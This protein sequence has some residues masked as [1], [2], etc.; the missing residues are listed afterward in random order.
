MG[1]AAIGMEMPRPPR[2]LRAG[3]PKA[4]ELLRIALLAGEREALT[5]ARRFC[6]RSG[7]LAL[8]ELVFC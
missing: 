3:G 8:G 2:P 5:S 1:Y 4:R 6:L 7:A